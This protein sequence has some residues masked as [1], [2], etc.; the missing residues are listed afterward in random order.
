MT[1]K[2]AYVAIVEFLEQ[3]G[4]KKV[5]SVIKD[6]IAMASA[7]TGGGGGKAT[8]F[9]RDEKSQVVT[10]VRCF[11]HRLWM[12]PQIVDFGAKASSATGLNSM[13]KDGVSKWTKRDRAYKAGKEG[14]LADLINEE[15]DFNQAD[16]ADAMAALETA[17]T[18]IIPREDGY[19]FE[20][21]EDCLA[22]LANR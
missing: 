17:K 21:L 14:L 18:Q 19:G 12:S 5:K 10:A 3:N 15:V 16:L 8:A 1:I 4:E 9:H 7:R 6:V 22:D 2:K 11:Y 20:T 13:C